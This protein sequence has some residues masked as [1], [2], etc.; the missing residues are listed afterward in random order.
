MASS[1]KAYGSHE[2]LPYRED[3]ALRPVYPYDVSKGCTDM[4]ARSYAATY[5]M[6]IAVTRL[7]NVYGGGDLN[8]SRIVPDTARALVR[9]ERPVVRSDGTPR[10]DFIYV[11]DAVDAYWQWR[12]RST[13]A[14]CA[15]GRGTPARGSPCR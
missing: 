8:F 6:P 3:F 7:A 12:A 1:D 11:E 14:I 4:I 10:R 15:G 2:E 5:G 9:G 13:G